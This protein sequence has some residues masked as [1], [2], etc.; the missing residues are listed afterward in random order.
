MIVE[1][2]LRPIDFEGSCDGLHESVEAPRRF[3]RIALQYL[4]A[5][6]SPHGDDAFSPPIGFTGIG[7]IGL[8]LG[9]RE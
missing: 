1:R 7:E 9:R 5:A 2:V 4:F 3:A 6:S 8:L